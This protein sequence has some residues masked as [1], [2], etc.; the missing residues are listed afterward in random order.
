MKLR[1]PARRT[2][3]SR[4]IILICA[5]VTA[6]LVILFITRYFVGHWVRIH[7]D[8]MAPSIKAG[9]LR[10]A[11]TRIHPEAGD[12]VLVEGSKQNLV[13]RIV[14]S[15]GDRISLSRGL[16]FVNGTRLSGR[17]ISTYAGADSPHHPWH[18]ERSKS[19]PNY[20]VI[21]P[22]PRMKADTHLS[23]K[24]VTVPDNAF[25]VLCDNRPGC[26]GGQAFGLVKQS[27][28]VGVVTGSVWPSWR[29]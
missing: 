15:P 27:R 28:V 7:G 14:A 18:L 22:N 10:F 4:P 25:F 24:A 29:R 6:I 1:S 19:G 9:E 2:H 16:V 12:V 26:P 17:R 23:L 11:N 5:F 21:V 8:S 3:K 20:W 13:R